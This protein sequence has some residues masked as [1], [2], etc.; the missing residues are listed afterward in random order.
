MIVQSTGKDN[1]ASISF[2]VLKSDMDKA[3]KLCEELKKDLGAI[4]R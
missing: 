1:K 3:L 2:T 4:G